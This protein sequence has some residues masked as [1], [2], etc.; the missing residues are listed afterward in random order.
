MGRF[1][2]ERGRIFG[3]VNV[4]DILVLLPF[5]GNPFRKSL[6]ILDCIDADFPV[7]VLVRRPK[8]AKRRYAEGDPLIREAFDH[9]RILYERNR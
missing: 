5:K 6:E 9:G 1:L 8:D 2:D 7:D 4:V 3:K